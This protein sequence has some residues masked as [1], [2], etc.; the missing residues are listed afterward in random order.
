M[1]HEEIESRFRGTGDFIVRELRC[2][3]FDLYA[4][5]VDGLVS[6]AGLDVFPTEPINH[7]SPILKCEN[8]VLTPHIGGVTY[9]SFKRMMSEAMF[10]IASFENGD[11]SRIENRRYI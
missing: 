3:G 7:D 1:T 8:V 9:D 5:A 2:C 6:G 11:M 4:Y 10:N